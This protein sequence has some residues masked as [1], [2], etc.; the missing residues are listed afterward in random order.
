M[1]SLLQ[2]ITITT[3]ILFVLMVVL[4]WR[5]FEF[6]EYTS[7]SLQHVRQQVIKKYVNLTMGGYEDYYELL[8]LMDEEVNDLLQAQTIE[9][10]KSLELS[11]NLATGIGSFLQ[12]KNSKWMSLYIFILNIIFNILCMIATNKLTQTLQECFDY[13][14][15]ERKHKLPKK[16]VFLTFHKQLAE[17]K[18]PEIK[19]VNEQGRSEAFNRILPH[20]RSELV[21]SVQHTYPS[22]LPLFIYMIIIFFTTCIHCWIE[23][24]EFLPALQHISEYINGIEF[25]ESIHVVLMAFCL[26]SKVFYVTMV[27]STAEFFIQFCSWIC[28]IKFT[29]QPLLIE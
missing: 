2:S 1:P 26:L 18:E 15:K 25:D 24:L 5:L 14:P 29:P 13:I 10:K 16:N 21:Q 8:N 17:G 3:C 28:R 9:S 7:S 20:F 11:L 6:K 23:S 4:S 19:V 22:L 27:W 12:I